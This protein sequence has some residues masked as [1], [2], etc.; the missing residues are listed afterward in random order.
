MEPGVDTRD[1]KASSQYQS[2]S[3]DNL[4]YG[5]DSVM[6]SEE[7]RTQEYGGGESSSVERERGGDGQRCEQEIPT[8]ERS[9]AL[10]VAP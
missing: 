6:D 1:K 3:A 9:L 4:G 7:K 10:R 5:E 8:A 2:W